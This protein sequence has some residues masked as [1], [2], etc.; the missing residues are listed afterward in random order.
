[1]S[2]IGRVDMFHPPKTPLKMVKNLPI[3][4]CKFFLPKFFTVQIE[5]YTNR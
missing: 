3:T 2:E 4:F 1:M 5:L